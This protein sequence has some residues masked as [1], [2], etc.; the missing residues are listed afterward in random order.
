MA[1]NNQSQDWNQRSRNKDNY[2]KNDDDDDDDDDD[3]N[4]NNR[5][6]FFE[7]INKIDKPLA[8]LT[9]EHK[10]ASKLTIQKWRMRHNNRNWRN[11]KKS[12]NTTTKVYT[13]QNWKI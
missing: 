8:K 1:G 7:R 11:F 10:T 4:N 9:R 3:D 6:W 13:Q 12:S 2:T 5:I